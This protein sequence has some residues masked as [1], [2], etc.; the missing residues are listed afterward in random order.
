MVSELGGRLCGRE[1]DKS[2]ESRIGRETSAGPGKQ[3]KLSGDWIL[4][5]FAHRRGCQRATKIGGNKQ[6]KE[7]EKRRLLACLTGAAR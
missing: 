4:V 3:G 2:K 5:W 6:G 7:Q 1:G